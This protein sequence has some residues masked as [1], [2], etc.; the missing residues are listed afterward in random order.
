[1]FGLVDRLLFRP[2]TRLVDASTVHRVYLYRRTVQGDER[3]TGGIYARYLD[4]ARWSTTAS[5]T[6]GAVLR[7][8]A[9]GEG[10]G[11]QVRNVAV[12][13]AEFFR[14][15]DAPPIL[16]RYFTPSEDV[17]PSPAA[18]AVL[19]SS[20][21]RTQY[22]SRRDVLGSTVRIDAAA[23]TIIGVAPDGFVGLWPYQPPAAFIPV[24][25]Y[26]ANRGR[27]DWAATYGTAFGLEIITRRRPDVSLA[28]ASADFTSALVRS[29]QFQNAGLP[30]A[31]SIS[32]LRPRAIVA[33]IL[34][35]RGPEAS[36]V[37]RAATWLSG[38]T[39]I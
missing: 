10:Q 6:A 11:T 22:G 4:L 25:T 27:P 14:F 32:D 31:R 37:T 15:F 16:G 18:V 9:V 26:A 12:V 3:Q 13:S 38:V 19:S 33:S 28:A 39:L 1:M 29:Y 2:P 8:L 34:S 20:L 30:D 24:A 17:P 7:T 35:E 36:S 21:W 5:Q 23:Y